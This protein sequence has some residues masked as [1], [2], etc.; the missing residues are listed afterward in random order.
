MKRVFGK[1]YAALLLILMAAGES[2]VIF[3]F[4]WFKGTNR[5]AAVSLGLS[6]W[7]L[8]CVLAPTIHELGHI[9]AAKK[10]GKNQFYF[11]PRTDGA[12]RSSAAE[13]RNL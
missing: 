10:Q 12:V 6:G 3:Y 9:V 13:G 4:A 2:F 8:S 1:I 11:L 5:V 7:L